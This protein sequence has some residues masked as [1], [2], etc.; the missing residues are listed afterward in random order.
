MRIVR[1]QSIKMKNLLSI[2]FILITVTA[3]NSAVATDHPIE[4]TELIGT[5]LILISI[6]GHPPIADRMISLQINS[7][8]FSGS[9][10]CNRYSA[11]YTA[12]SQNSFSIDELAMNEAD[13]IEPEGIMKQENRYT[14]LLSSAIKCQLIEQELVLE[15]AQGKVI[16][17]YQPRPEFEV[18]PDALV[19]KT[20]Q[21]IS[22][23]DLYKGN[24][25]EFSI[26]F[27]EGTFSGT[28]VCREYE[29]K[30]RAEEDTF[31]ITFM[32]TTT[33]YN[34]NEKDGFA[35]AQFTTLLSNVEQYNV[36]SDQLELFTRHGEK[37]IFELVLSDK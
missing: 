31:Q 37:L 19:G 23:P 6:E 17:R 14:E 26:R 27:D 20:W 33:D 2:L 18:T 3:C 29:G 4:F 10:G 30:Y 9:A 35:E 32:S 13:C 16:L 7:E 11:R 34:C 5:N 25:S 28:T 36:T 1:R 8:Y 15:D 24:L 12:K 21:L 22:A